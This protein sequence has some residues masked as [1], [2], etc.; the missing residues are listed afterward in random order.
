M[1]D[2]AEWYFNR[3][4]WVAGTNAAQAS[5]RAMRRQLL[6]LLPHCWFKATGVGAN[7]IPGHTGSNSGGGEPTWVHT[8]DDTTANVKWR[9]NLTWTSSEIT[10]ISFQFDDNSGGGLVTLGDPLGV[11]YAGET[12]PPVV[13]ADDDL[14]YS[15]F[16][17]PAAANPRKTCNAITRALRD[18]AICMAVYS[19]MRGTAYQSWLLTGFTQTIVGGTTTPTRIDLDGGSTKPFFRYTLTHRADGSLWRVKI[20]TQR[21]TGEPL[22]TLDHHEYAYDLDDRL[23]SIRSIETS[24]G[25]V[26][27]QPRLGLEAATATRTPDNA[28]NGEAF[29]HEEPQDATTTQ[30][31]PGIWMPLALNQWWTLAVLGW[32][33][34]DPTLY[35]FPRF[36]T[37]H[38]STLFFYADDSDGDA[39]RPAAVEHQQGNFCVRYQNSYSAGNL[40]TSKW[41]VD[42]AIGD[43]FWAFGTI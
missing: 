15:F 9:A 31:T 39:G 4:Q 32:G 18:N 38:S 14:A 6:W 13:D 27:P 11:V 5:V 24:A 30:L 29:D 17:D 21:K 42:P 36:S 1:A 40:A 26:L 23:V 3:P 20:D 28:G 35:K 33:G 7:Q 19:A 37:G 8:D 16:F 41:Y 43:G 2:T 25:G 22:Y 34:K 10:A 12:G